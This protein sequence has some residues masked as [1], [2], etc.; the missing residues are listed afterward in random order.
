ML[1][2]NAQ[3]L[4]A[5]F[6]AAAASP[7]PPVSA[8]VLEQA[9]SL[10]RPP[11][12]IASGS[13]STRSLGCTIASDSSSALLEQVRSLLRVPCLAWEL[14]QPD[15][16]TPPPWRAPEDALGAGIAEDANADWDVVERPSVPTPADVDDV[17]HWE[18]A[19][20]SSS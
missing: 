18:A 9:R 13:I 16:S 2:A 4:L 14:Q 1:R 7:P 19:T 5:P 11:R 17:D 6:A 12:R 8:H 15:E 3:H 10:A 20:A